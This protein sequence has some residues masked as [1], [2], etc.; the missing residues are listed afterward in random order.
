YQFAVVALDP[1]NNMSSPRTVTFTTAPSTDTT[2]PAAPSSS[3]V[4]ATPFSSSRI[5]VIW[6]ASS[7]SDASGYQIFGDGALVGEVY[8]PM[9]RYF[10]DNGLAP[11]STHSYQIRTIDSAGNLSALTTGRQATTLANGVVKIV[12]GPYL[13][14]TS[15]NSTRIA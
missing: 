3:S 7:S 4:T 12:R 2:A 15:T 11:S 13:Q 10:S 14:Q 5:D 9:R 1:T 8:L 6:A